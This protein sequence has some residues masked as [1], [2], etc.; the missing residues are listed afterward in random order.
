MASTS[1]EVSGECF[2]IAVHGDGTHRAAVPP[3]DPHVAGRAQAEARRRAL[4]L[5]ALQAIA[6][7]HGGRVQIRA[8]RG[9]GCT[10]DASFASRPLGHGV[11]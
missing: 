3:A 5:Q 7:P 9:I 1:S 6:Q 2:R 4:M 11:A 8:D 10:V